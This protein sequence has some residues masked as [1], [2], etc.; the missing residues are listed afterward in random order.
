MIRLLILL[1]ISSYVLSVII[2]IDRYTL[3]FNKQFTNWSTSFTHNEHRNAVVNLTLETYQPMTKLLIYV[4][5]NLAQ[6]KNDQ[7]FKW[8]FFKTIY[9]AEKVANEAQTNFLVGAFV[10]NVRKFTDFKLQFPLKAVSLDS[11]FYS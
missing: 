7:E 9:N 1:S 3:D 6:N 4:K 8:Q 11:V 10:Q 5:C 2:S